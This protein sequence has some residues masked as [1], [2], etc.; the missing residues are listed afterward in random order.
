MANLRWRILSVP[1][2]IIYHFI[3][4][5]LLLLKIFCSMFANLR[6]SLDTFLFQ[7]FDLIPIFRGQK[8]EIWVQKIKLIDNMASNKVTLHRYSIFNR[9]IILRNYSFTAFVNMI[10]KSQVIQTRNS[11]SR[12]DL[13][14]IHIS[15]HKLVI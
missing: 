2:F 7:F 13:M 8:G 10:I 11:T 12:K 14:K 1:S 15:N 5:S 4:T 6:I 9:S 3:V